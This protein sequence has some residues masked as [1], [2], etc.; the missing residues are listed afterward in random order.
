MIATI[1]AKKIRQTQVF[2]KNDRRWPATVFEA[3]PC[4]V[5]QVK[6]DTTDGYTAVQLGF[7]TK[8]VHKVA[9]PQ[10]GH[11]KKARLDTMPR[12]LQ[13]VRVVDKT[14]TLPEVGSVMTIDQLFAPGDVVSVA[15]TSK[16]KGFAGVVKRHKFAG[17]PATHG[18]SDRERAPGSIG[19]TTTPGRVYR[20]KRMAGRMGS[21]TVT[22][23]GLRVMT[24]DSAHHTLTISGLVPGACGSLLTISR[25]SPL[26]IKNVQENAD[27][28]Q[29][30][31]TT[32]Q[33]QKPQ[34]QQTPKPEKTTKEQPKQTKEI[35]VHEND[36]KAVSQ[37]PI[38]E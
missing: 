13:E 35:H 25:I 4:P 15:G 27:A 28:A 9:K 36:T 20:G 8:R 34:D 31:S 7:G 1:I 12:F 5:V 22:V 38:K 10:Q 16:G 19:G 2:D 21:E 26:T 32:L 30:T 6:T 24:V 23:K 11:F 14:G 3:G 18:Q 17:G 33:T 37:Q 29:P